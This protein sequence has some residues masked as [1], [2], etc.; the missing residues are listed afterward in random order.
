MLHVV[1]GH[2]PSHDTRTGSFGA[3]RCGPIRCG[4]VWLCRCLLVGV[5][6]QPA[7][8]NRSRRSVVAPAEQLRGSP[9]RIRTEVGGTKTHHDGP[10]HYRAVICPDGF[11]FLSLSALN[12]EKRQSNWLSDGSLT[13]DLAL[14][15]NSLRFNTELF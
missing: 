6:H 14:F 3:N 9:T 13:T 4:Y 10:L 1:L 8:T 7:R 15:M 5:G 12:D 11:S 2:H